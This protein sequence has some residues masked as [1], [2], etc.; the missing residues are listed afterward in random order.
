MNLVAEFFQV[1][2]QDTNK[3]KMAAF[4][5]NDFLGLVCLLEHCSE[6]CTGLYYVVNKGNNGL[7]KITDD[8]FLVC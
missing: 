4:P 2:Q 5:E 3:F 7:H 6:D 1:L 8:L